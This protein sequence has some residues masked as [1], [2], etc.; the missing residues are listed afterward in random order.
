MNIWRLNVRS[1]QITECINSW[2]FAL[3]SKPRNPEIQKGDVLLLQL[4]ASD[5]D[6]FDKR[7]SRIEFALYFDHYEQDYDGAISKYY[8]PNAG[9]T[10]HWILHCNGM[11]STIPFSLEKLNLINNYSG[12]T[13]PM[14][15]KSEDVNKVMF[16]LIGIPLKGE[17]IGDKIHTALRDSAIDKEYALLA[18]IKNNDRIV[19]SNPNQINWTTVPAHKE[20]KRN[21]ELPCLLKEFYSFKC[22]ICGHDFL[23]EGYE[24]PY[25]E[26]HHIL[27]ILRGG[28]DHSNNLIVVCPNHHR[29]IH[30]EDPIFDR[31][32]LVFVYKNGLNEH[33]ENEGH[34]NDPVLLQK[35]EQW[36]I[37]RE[38]QIKKEKIILAN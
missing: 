16:Y 28:M 6:K 19:E 10:W 25:S 1:T 11:T 7:N 13:N 18:A 38:E 15:I 2:K 22:Q 30:R 29:I 17:S 24:H 9:K 8:W 12:Q 3:D 23:E 5:A 32:K 14:I 35:V 34:L 20:I 36:A 27:W 21:A 26:T 37:E 31:N 33:L 4:V